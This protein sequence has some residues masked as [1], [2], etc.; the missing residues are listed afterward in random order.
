[1]GIFLK[2]ILSLNFLCA[3]CALCGEKIKNDH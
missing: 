3:L 2:V 1:M